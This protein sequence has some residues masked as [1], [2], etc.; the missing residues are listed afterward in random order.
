MA[1]A[2]C[3]S[4]TL[5]GINSFGV[6]SVRFVTLHVQRGFRREIQPHRATNCGVNWPR[7]R[8]YTGREL[9]ECLEDHV[10][11]ISAHCRDNDGEFWIQRGDRKSPRA[12]D[13]RTG[14]EIWS[15]GQLLWRDSSK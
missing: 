8:I 7:D 12:S 5:E 13:Q 11:P 14:E 15:S 6:R 10:S 2:R 4:L 3:R 1:L 9:G